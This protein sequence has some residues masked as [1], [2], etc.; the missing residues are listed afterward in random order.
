MR[1]SLGADGR[2][3]FWIQLRSGYT[4]AMKTSSPAPSR[5][6]FAQAL[7]VLAATAGT[8]T[9]Q[10]AARPDAKA[11]AAAL[12]TVIRFRFGAQMSDEQIKQAVSAAVNG[13]RSSDRLKSVELANGDDPI[14]AFRAD[15]P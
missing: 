8:A 15:L 14:A 12:E 7:A 10:V 9:A 5:R 2:F 4:P 11:Y 3:C 6:D 13:R 1:G